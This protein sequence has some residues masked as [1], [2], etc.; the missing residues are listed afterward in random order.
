MFTPKITIEAN[1]NMKDI[2]DYINETVNHWIDDIA[3][4]MFEAGK[5]VVDKAR[6]Q[7]KAEGGFGNITYN[8]RSSIGCVVV[9]NHQIL[10]KHIYFPKIGKGDEGH[11]Q[12]IAYAREI[13]LL[14]DDG[15]VFIVVVAGMEYASFL[16]DNGHDV[17]SGS[18]ESFKKLFRALL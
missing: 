2:E 18:C 7:T 14:L 16:E 17:I 3:D 6:A 10:D 1:F 8:L 12:G 5:I 4:S 11:K 15:D 13:A 9:S